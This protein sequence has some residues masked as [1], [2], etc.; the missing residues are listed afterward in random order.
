MD[1]HGHMSSDDKEYEAFSFL[2]DIVKDRLKDYYNAIVLATENAK[3]V[4]S[5]QP[6]AIKEF[7]GNEYAVKG[8]ARFRWWML[9]IQDIVKSENIFEKQFLEAIRCAAYF[10]KD[11]RELKEH[12]VKITGF[13]FS[14]SNAFEDYDEDGNVTKSIRIGI[15][16]PEIDAFSQIK[17]KDNIAETI[18][19]G[20]Y[21]EI[22]KIEPIPYVNRSYFKSIKF[23][24]SK[25]TISLN[26]FGFLKTHSDDKEKFSHTVSFENY[27][28]VNS[29]E[30]KKRTYLGAPLIFSGKILD[31]R[32]PNIKIQGIS[33]NQMESFTFSPKFKSNYPIVPGENIRILVMEW[34]VPQNDE[35]VP[36]EA[37]V[38]YIEKINDEKE[39]ISDEATG[40]VRIRKN[41]TVKDYESKFGQDVNTNE[42]FKEGD[43]YQFSFKK[44]H[45]E[46]VLQKYLDCTNKLRRLR[47]ESAT[48]DTLLVQSNEIISDEDL[49]VKNIV[50]RLRN[51]QIEKA[52]VYH[53]AKL[54]DLKHVFTIDEL[55]EEI[56]KDTSI[57]IADEDFL[58]FKIRLIKGRLKLIE[59]SVYGHKISKIG[60]EILVELFKDD[61]TICT[62]KQMN[63]DFNSVQRFQI[64]SVQMKILE[65]KGMKALDDSGAACKIFWIDPNLNYNA[66]ELIGKIRDLCY[67][68][69]Q[70]VASQQGRK[71]LRF[72]I[73]SDVMDKG[74]ETDY[75]SVN[76]ALDYLVNKKEIECEDDKFDCSYK[77]ALI[78]VLRY[79]RGFLSTEELFAKIRKPG[80]DRQVMSE[81]EDILTDANVSKIT[82]PSGLA[83]W[84]IFEREGEGENAK[85]N[86]IK[87]Y[88]KKDLKGYLKRS[89]D[90]SQIYVMIK[91][92]LNR[93]KKEF[94]LEGDLDK[95]AERILNELEGEEFFR[96][97]GEMYSIR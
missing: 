30:S 89:K 51:N 87:K 18:E 93:Y 53:A 47:Q 28:A 56:R 33:S 85:R 72:G 63:L 3:N 77:D 31:Y 26:E 55:K 5:K 67:N 86:L 34:Y 20:K 58:D 37:E 68:L 14:K 36:Q 2:Q 7:H 50:A 45:S 38:C 60:I 1:K 48:S 8:L 24:E 78:N 90:R 91:T 22:S 17:I 69:Y 6:L 4:I 25:K 82:D 65:R 40:Y 43:S 66:D 62:S 61:A 12:T 94:R 46:P 88:L 49:Y 23:T 95:N 19:V 97:S 9:F 70:I 54:S 80:V 42:I 32:F 44:N 21:Y 75:F 35:N 29:N 81:I 64:P 10:V 96:I 71:S 76:H 83:H 74:I 57:E 79:E 59:N 27:C 52:I 11:I 15:I 16:L 92:E 39:I 41:V 73:F 84:G 13:V